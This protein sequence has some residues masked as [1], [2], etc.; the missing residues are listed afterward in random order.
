ML[1]DPTSV[2]GGELYEQPYGGVPFSRGWIIGADQTV[3]LP[4]FGHDPQRVID[5]I[6]AL[7]EEL[8]PPGDVDGNGIVDVEDIVAVILGWG[9]CAG[10]NA[11]PADV[12]GDGQV[13]VDDLLLVIVNWST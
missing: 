7:L 6:D 4:L 3:V 2:V 12:T 10:G 1:F 5:A 8:P 9:P 11:C 13:G